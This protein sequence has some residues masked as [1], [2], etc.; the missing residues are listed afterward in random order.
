M[1]QLGQNCG[2]LC[3]EGTQRG[4]AAGLGASGAHNGNQ[5][6]SKQLARHAVLCF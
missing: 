1:S 2:I 3:A 5:A 4:L 6:E